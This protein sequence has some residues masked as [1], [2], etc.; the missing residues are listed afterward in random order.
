LGIRDEVFLGVLKRVRLRFPRCG[1]EIYPEIKVAVL[2]GW[3]KAL[4]GS[5]EAW[6]AL[7]QFQKET[8]TKLFATFYRNPLSPSCRVND[9]TI[10]GKVEIWMD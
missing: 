6:Q 9:R 8:G 4:D 3:E 10:K 1:Q 2:K 7:Q 5:E